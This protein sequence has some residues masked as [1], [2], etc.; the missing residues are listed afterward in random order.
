M[1]EDIVICTCNYRNTSHGCHWLQIVAWQ[2]VPVSVTLS[3]ATIVTTLAAIAMTT[4][5][6]LATI[7]QHLHGKQTVWL[8]YSTCRSPCSSWA[9]CM[10]HVDES[11]ITAP[12]PHISAVCCFLWEK[13]IRDNTDL[14]WKCGNNIMNRK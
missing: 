3:M 6:Y 2:I 7:G 5:T 4:S 11:M 9:C 13:L 8:P 14:I 10:L 12:L 1:Y